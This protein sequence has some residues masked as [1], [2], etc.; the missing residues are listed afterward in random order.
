MIRFLL[1]QFRQACQDFRDNCC[2]LFFGECSNTQPPQNFASQNNSNAEPIN[3]GCND[4]TNLY[5]FIRCNAPIFTI[6]GIT[7]T[8]LSLIP[9]FLDKFI[10]PGWI[11]DLLT[12]YNGFWEFIVINVIIIFGAIFILYLA[13]ALAKRL[14]SRSFNQDIIHRIGPFIFTRGHIEK[15]LF[16]I[17]FFPLILAFVIFIVSIYSFQSDP[18]F[19]LI[20]LLVFSILYL[21]MLLLLVY[22]AILTSHTTNCRKNFSLLVVSMIVILLIFGAY[23][24]ISPLASQFDP[25]NPNNHQYGIVEIIHNNLT[26]SIENSSTIGLPFSVGGSY[27]NLSFDDIAYYIKFHWTTNY[28][29]FITNDPGDNIKIQ[30]ADCFLNGSST[31]YWTYDVKDEPF[32]KP[33]VII[34]L[35]VEN[36]RTNS[37][38]N[39]TQIKMNWSENNSVIIE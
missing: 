3:N 38:L 24:L 30:G 6:I 16:S 35:R 22:S 20:G 11:S 27:Q 31:V 18:Y 19:K 1:L 29:Y 12:S 36:K 25:Y 23:L 17:V 5:W 33:P 39:S 7:G 32:K 21:I 10:G 8:M 26:Y 28:G 34:S 37:V 4:N 2:E 14:I 9:T 13:I 15:I